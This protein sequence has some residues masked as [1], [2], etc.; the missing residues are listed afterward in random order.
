VGGS[1]S[2][3]QHGDTRQAVQVVTVRAGNRCV[4]WVRVLTRVDL[5][6]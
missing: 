6:P 3:A 4:E 5:D 1:R 2:I